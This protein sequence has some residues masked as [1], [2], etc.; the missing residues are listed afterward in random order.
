MLRIIFSIFSLFVIPAVLVMFPVDAQSDPAD[1]E[2]IAHMKAGHKKVE[3]VVIDMKSGLYTV[4]TPTGATITLTESAA[5]R[6]G[7]DIPKVGDEMTV[8]V[9]E[10]NMVI[11]AHMKGQSG[12]PHR[13][14][15]G[16]LASVDNTKSQMTLSTSGGE[17]HFKLKPES[18]MFKDIAPGTQVTIELNETGEVIDL[19]KDKQ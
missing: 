12:K 7:R 8:W 19:H 6:Q 5:V 15:S 10:G 4:K 3:G 11:D 13:F 9:N 17:K 18:R 14:I 1:P 2:E 16:T